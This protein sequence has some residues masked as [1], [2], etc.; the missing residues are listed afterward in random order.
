MS[1]RRLLTILGATVVAFVL[2]APSAKAQT[3][4]E[5]LNPTDAEPSCVFYDTCTWDTQ[6]GGTTAYSY[7][8]ARSSQGQKCQDVVEVVIPNSICATGCNMCA[9]VNHSASCECNSA[10]LKLTGNCTYW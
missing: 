9:S 1:D 3:G 2:L 4:R 6:P 8:L 5:P 10:S 7:C